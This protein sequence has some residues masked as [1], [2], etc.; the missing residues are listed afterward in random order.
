MENFVD[1]GHLVKKHGLNG[2]V[3]I[4]I[5]EDYKEDL[6]KTEKIFIEHHGQKIPYFIDEIKIGKTM[7]IRLEDI[8]TPEAA[9]QLSNKTIYLHDSDIHDQQALVSDHPYQQLVGMRIEDVTQGIIGSIQE[10]ISYPGQEMA[11]VVKEDHN[12][13]IPLVASYIIDMDEEKGS[14]K[15]QLPLGLIDL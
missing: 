2:D 10:I 6:Q 14:I 7:Y 5:N 15:M 3:L 9:D 1:V 12:I 13:M 11:I 4:R 8:D